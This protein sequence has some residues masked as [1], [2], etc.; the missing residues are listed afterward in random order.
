M[1]GVEGAN[2]KKVARDESENRK[3]KINHLQK[4]V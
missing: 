3:E 2:R 4:N 1:E